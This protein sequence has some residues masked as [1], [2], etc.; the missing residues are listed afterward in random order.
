[1]SAL[2]WSGTDTVQAV[3]HFWQPVQAA[4]ST[5]RAFCLIVAWNRPSAAGLDALDLAV[6]QGRDVGVVDGRRHLRRRDAARAVE[7]REDLAEQDHLPADAGLLLDEQDPVAHV[8]EL[9]GGLH[10]ADPGA[11]DE[12]VV[13][14]HDR[15]ADG[16]KLGQ[17]LAEL[18]DVPGERLRADRADGGHLQPRGLVATL[19]QELLGLRD[20]AR[21]PGGAVGEVGALVAVGGDE[22]AVE[23]V[24][25][26]VQDPARSDPAGAGQ[27]DDHD[28]R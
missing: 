28:A 26:G 20:D 21:G 19:D 23:P 9:E 22:D 5:N 17:R 1:M 4:S 15:T 13:V 3:S 10:A 7:G 25:D 12:D 14:R 27:A 16:P 8:A 11:D 2:N 6:G 18:L 24:L